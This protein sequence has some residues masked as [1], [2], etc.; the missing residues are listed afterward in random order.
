MNSST[1]IADPL[2]VRV[3]RERVLSSGVGG[4]ELSGTNSALTTI[5]RQIRFTRN[6]LSGRACRAH[7]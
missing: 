6:A 2:R 4:S 5:F 7:E 1:A 3:K